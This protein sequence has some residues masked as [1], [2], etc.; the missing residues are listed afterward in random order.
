[1]T[2][3][4]LVTV[5]SGYAKV[6]PLTKPQNEE[7]PCILYQRIDT[8]QN[9]YQGGKSLNRPRF[10]ITCLASSKK[11]AEDLANLVKAE[12]DLNKTDF[13]LSHLINQFDGQEQEEN[14]YKTILEFYI[15]E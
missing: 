12:L 5:L 15:F 11:G 14:L 13:I 2:E 6:F 8:Q 4:T 10:Q 3:Q 1:M 7:L 9:N